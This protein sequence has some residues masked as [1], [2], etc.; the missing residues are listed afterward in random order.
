MFFMGFKSRLSES[1][2]TFVQDFIFAV[3]TILQST[4]GRAAVT[5]LFYLLLSVLIN[6][7]IYLEFYY[8]FNQL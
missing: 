5:F 4:T 6:E 3:I 1:I 2:H 7:I 8:F